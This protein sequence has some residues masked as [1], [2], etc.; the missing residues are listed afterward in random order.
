MKSD[1]LFGELLFTCK[2][3]VVVVRVYRGDSTFT[4]TR[5]IDPAVVEEVTKVDSYGGDI[6]GYILEATLKWSDLEREGV[7]WKP[8]FKNGDVNGEQVG[9]F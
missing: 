2:G 7:Q 6:T 9:T 3:S 5:V 4:I 1:R 8:Q